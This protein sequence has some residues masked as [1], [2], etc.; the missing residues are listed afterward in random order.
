MIKRIQKHIIKHKNAY[1]FLTI[2]FI[3]GIIT[4]IFLVG[5]IDVD[6]S[7]RLVTYLLDPMGSIENKQE[8]FNVQFTTN[9]LSILFI[10]FLGFSI[11]GIPFIAFFI[12]TKGVQIGFSSCLFILAYEWKGVFGIIIALLPQILFDL[13][14]FY[15]ISIVAY[16]LSYSFLRVIIDQKTSIRF[17]KLF[18]YCMNDLLI[19]AIIVYF[20][21][22]VK[23]TVVVYFIELFTQWK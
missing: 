16:E 19:A 10:F 20:S 12:F 1:L 3:G 4:G 14:A 22:Y 13:I 18:S 17:K 11:I 7:N 2:L 6:Q 23:V 9:I 21:S 15:L 8:Y 5:K